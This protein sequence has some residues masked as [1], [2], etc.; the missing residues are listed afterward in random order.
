METRINFKLKNTIEVKLKTFDELKKHFENKNKFTLIKGEEITNVVNQKPFHVNALNIEKLILPKVIPPEVNVNPSYIIQKNIDD[1]A[2]QGID[3]NKPT[4]AVLNHP[5][6]QRSI[7]SDIISEIKKL[8]HI[9]IYN[10][11]PDSLSQGDIY[12]HPVTHLWD[13]ENTLRLS[14]LNKNLLYGVA[15]DDSH[16]YYQFDTTKANPG[17]GWIMVNSLS[18]SVNELINNINLGNYYSSTG[19]E[20]SNILVEE[21]SLKITIKEKPG[22]TYLTL[23]IGSIEKK[24][25]HHLTK[26]KSIR[27]KKSFEISSVLEISKSNPAS[28]TFSNKD[29]FVRAKV[30]TINTMKND[31]SLFKNES[32][33]TQPVIN[34]NFKS[35]F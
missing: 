31:L 24:P 22:V 10:G 18:N 12:H 25:P 20:I 9:E 27:I 35:G 16:N 4:L 7:S 19:V 33:W 2:Q 32:A 23:F 8:K 15:S 13:I 1:I 5:N 34:N 11:Y 21:D 3:F 29:L 14:S 17:K 6:M 28:Y 30:I 26:K